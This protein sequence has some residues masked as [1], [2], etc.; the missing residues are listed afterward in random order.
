ML[1]APFTGDRQPCQPA[2]HN[3]SSFLAAGEVQSTL[4]LHACASTDEFREDAM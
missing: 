2:S 1:P 3:A 4:C